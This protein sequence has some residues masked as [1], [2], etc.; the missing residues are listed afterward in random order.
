MNKV[1]RI[2]ITLQHANAEVTAERLTAVAKKLADN[3]SEGYFSGQ[4]EIL[5][6]IK[7]IE[8]RDAGAAATLVEAVRQGLRGREIEDID[9]AEFARDFMHAY[10]DVRTAR[11][12]ASSQ[13]RS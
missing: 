11:S 13:S 9:D 3:W 7:L 8:A 5:K 4:G 6:L 1:A 12:S 2:A 10:D